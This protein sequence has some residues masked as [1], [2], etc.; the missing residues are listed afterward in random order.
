MILRG[1]EVARAHGCTTGT[2]WE[3]APGNALRGKIGSIRI[4]LVAVAQGPNIISSSADHDPGES[5]P[6][7]RAARQ[8]LRAA[9]GAGGA[10]TELRGALGSEAW[11]PRRGETPGLLRPLCKG[12]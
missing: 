9:L 7:A 4:S 2:G 1:E 6:A 5:G 10:D 8:S 12:S 11:G 3:M